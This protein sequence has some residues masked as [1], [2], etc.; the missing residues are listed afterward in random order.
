MTVM[1]RRLGLGSSVGVR[2]VGR[3]VWRLFV[4]VSHGSY[5]HVFEHVHLV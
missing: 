5:D 2:C 3:W 1:K 4:S